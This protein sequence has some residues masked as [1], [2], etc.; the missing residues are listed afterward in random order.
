MKLRG[1]LRMVEYLVK[2]KYNGVTFNGGMKSEQHINEIDQI[3]LD[4][5]AMSLSSPDNSE[6]LETLVEY[7]F[8]T[9]PTE[10]AKRVLELDYVKSIEV[11]KC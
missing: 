6:S 2:V 5:Y 1:M 9:D 3:A 10:F 7:D 11:K 4:H 8:V